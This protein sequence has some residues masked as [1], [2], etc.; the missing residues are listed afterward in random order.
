MNTY[1]GPDRRREPRSGKPPCRK[2]GHDDSLIVSCGNRLADAP[3]DVFPR[4]RECVRCG[5]T[6]RTYEIN[7]D[8]V[9]IQDMGL[10]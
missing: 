5:H 2:C 10:R 6:W 4:E 1:H 3:P 7:A 8:K 9:K